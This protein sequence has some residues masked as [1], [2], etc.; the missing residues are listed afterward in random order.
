MSS[1]EILQ[2]IT[3]LKKQNNYLQLFK[4][5]FFSYNPWGLISSIYMRYKIS[6]F[7]CPVC[8]YVSFPFLI[9]L[10]LYLYN[11]QGR[12]IQMYACLLKKLSGEKRTT[13]HDLFKLAP[14]CLFHTLR[15]FSWFEIL[16]RTLIILC[17]RLFFIFNKGFAFPMRS[18]K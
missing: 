3:I 12:K 10:T 1:S 8:T 2:M 4:H 18:I 14:K 11:P 16:A 13:N 15:L 9:M 5:I 17:L 7:Y 6:G